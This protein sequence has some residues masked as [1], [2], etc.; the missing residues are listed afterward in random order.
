MTSASASSEDAD[1]SGTDRLRYSVRFA[2][3]LEEECSGDLT[4]I[5]VGRHRLLRVIGEG[6]MGLVYAAEQIDTK[7]HCAVKVL[8][9]EFCNQPT[10]VER[11]MREARATARIDHPNIVEIGDVGPTPNGSV[12]F[13]MELLE[14]EDLGALLL[15]EG[16][17]PWPRAR[18]IMLHLCAALDAAHT[19]G[20]VHRDIKPSNC[21]RMSRGGDR[22][23]IKVLDFGI[24]KLLGEEHTTGKKLTRT[25]QIFGTPEYMSPEQVRG[26]PADPRMDIYSAGII[27]FELL[28][29]R[30][31]FE[32]DA[33]LE[34]LAKHLREPIPNASAT[35]GAQHMPRDLD[36]VVQRALAKDVAARY[37]S[38]T[39][40][41]DAIERIGATERVPV[42]TPPG[43]ARVR[44]P[45]PRA[46]SQP[47]VQRIALAVGMLMLAAAVTI[48]VVSLT[49]S[50]RQDTPL[51]GGPGQPVG[52]SDAAPS[53][54]SVEAISQQQ[55][56]AESRIEGV[57]SAPP[58]TPPMPA[59][60]AAVPVPSEVAP[61]SSTT[62]EA[63]TAT[64]VVALETR[65][66]KKEVRAI[67]RRADIF[68]CALRGRS[69]RT[70]ETVRVEVELAART[71]RVKRVAA[72][73]SGD[74][75]KIADCVATVVNALPFPRGRA[76][77]TETHTFQKPGG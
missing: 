21:F 14:G 5:V 53:A 7:R 15:R 28:T 18:H 58:N 66:T 37:Q 33:P 71:G 25:G 64:P 59:E 26:L 70:D 32:G 24:A 61:T 74:Q 54:S 30:T 11:F 17:Q 47:K 10:H 45:P 51:S 27:L 55:P 2:Q 69:W 31:P 22:D 73:H 76:G 48:G 41:R 77:S 44:T 63:A 49:W 13:A 46:T 23:F 68:G 38:A 52:P 43:Q 34:I 40:F 57:V 29:G 75:K 6:G 60:V 1:T 9:A 4:G 67:M 72:K 62:A 36:A 39:E 20:V 12:F 42:Y 3:D 56:R 19:H 50:G 35:R 16:A 65:L 8:S